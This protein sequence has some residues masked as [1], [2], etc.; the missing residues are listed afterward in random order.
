M[1]LVLSSPGADSRTFKPSHLS[2][3]SACET[4]ISNPLYP[5]HLIFVSITMPSKN[6]GIIDKIGK[7][8]APVKIL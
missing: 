1:R 5:Q 6:I 7:C 8:S 3:V 4:L 2:Q